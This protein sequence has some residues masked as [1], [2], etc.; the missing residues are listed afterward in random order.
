MISVVLADD[1]SLIREGIKKVLIRQPDL[2]VVCEAGTA[3]EVLDF[4]ARSQAHII[5]MDIN[6]PGMSGLDALKFVKKLS[7]TVHV[8]MLSMYPEDRFAIRALKAGAAGYITKGSAA[9]ELITAIK[10]VSAGKRYV[11]AATA[12]ML[13]EELSG[14]SEKLPHETLSD[15]EFQIFMM[16]VQGKTMKEVSRELV[17]SVNTVNTYRARILEKMKMSSVQDLMRYAFDN[18]LIQ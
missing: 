1:H 17:L 18:K 13:A 14:P 11:S 6:L 12:E 8:L 7:P 9:E 16:I 5:V 10:K 15:R 3:Q 2:E 4:L